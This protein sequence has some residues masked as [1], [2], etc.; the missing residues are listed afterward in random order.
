MEPQLEP[1]RHNRGEH[2]WRQ[3]QLDFEGPDDEIEQRIVEPDDDEIVG[4]MPR[5]VE[6]QIEG[7]RGRRRETAINFNTSLDSG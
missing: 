7:V 3:K 6:P 5:G 1:S 4:W 2:L